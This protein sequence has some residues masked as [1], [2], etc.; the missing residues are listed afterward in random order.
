MSIVIPFPPKQL[1]ERK[2][3]ISPVQTFPFH[4]QSSGQHSCVGAAMPHCSFGMPVHNEFSIACRV[5]SALGLF[6][7][8]SKKIARL[9]IRTEPPII[10]RYSSA[11]CAFEGI[12]IFSIIVFWFK[13]I[14]FFS[15][16]MEGYYFSN[17]T[18]LGFAPSSFRAFF[19]ASTKGGGP[20][21]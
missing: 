11:P 16:S 12:F 4:W 21:M 1:I 20:Q 6:A 10:S 7:L 14:S 8:V 3:A 5:F 13:I 2:L 19:I 9:A 15:K 17:T 18:A